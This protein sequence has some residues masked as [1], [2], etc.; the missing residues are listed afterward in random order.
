MSEQFDQ[1][2]PDAV[3]RSNRFFVALANGEPVDGDPGD[4]ALAGLLESWR[5]ESRT[6]ATVGVCSELAAVA[7]LNRGLVER[8]HSRRRAALT[9]AVA[10]AVLGIAGFGVLMGQA[11][12]G[13]PLYGARTSLFGEPSSAYDERIAVSAESDMDQV[14]QMIAV[15]QWDQAHDKLAAVGQNVQTVKNADRK[16]V[17]ID[18][19]NRLT[20]KVVSRDAHATAL[21]G[22]PAITL[23]P[24]RFGG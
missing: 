19:M 13:D 16:Q 22:A 23:A 7:A 24:N 14:E 5:D 15:G 6:P 10:A 17:L 11:Q 12:P 9:G 20:A 18:H 8:R 2:E 1:L 3:A 21:P 4:R